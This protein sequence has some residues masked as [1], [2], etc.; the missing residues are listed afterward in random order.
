[1]SKIKTGGWAEADGRIESGDTIEAVDEVE[2]KG[3]SL[4]TITA[5]LQGVEG[6][7]CSVTIVKPSG[8]RM[9]VQ[10]I[11]QKCV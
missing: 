9:T 1:V 8:E 10:G 3:S 2:C 6:S 7:P 5:M 4:E 11:R